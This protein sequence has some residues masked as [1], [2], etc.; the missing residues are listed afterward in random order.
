MNIEEIKQILPHRDSM[1]LL[2]EVTEEDGKAIGKKKITGSEWFLDGHFPGAPVVP[3]V[4]LCEIMAQS[5]CVLMRDKMT[6][7][8]LPFFSG[9]DKVKFKSPVRPGD[10]FTTE[11]E[12]IKERGIFYFAKGKGFV[13]NKLCVSAEF[14]FAVIDR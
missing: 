8:K 3:G 13:D 14:S 6:P 12:I 9:L 4:M 1:L 7:G 10:M 2:D 11:C 5:V